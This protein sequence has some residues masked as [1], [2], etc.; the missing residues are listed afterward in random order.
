M[1]E[2]IEILETETESS[3]Q[4][5]NRFVDEIFDWIEVFVHAFVLVILLLTF[6]FRI[7]NVDGSSMYPTLKDKEA[8]VI[9]NLFYEPGKGDIIVIAQPNFTHQPIVKRVIATGGDTIDINYETST[10]YVN[11]AAIEEP[12]LIEAM[13]V[14]GDTPLPL[15]LR[16]GE[17]FVMGDNRNGSTDSRS[18]LIGV[19]DERYV[20]GRTVLR[21][22]PINRMGLVH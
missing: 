1:D 11:G 6:I 8:I 18:N 19:I 14:R 7:V 13:E 12:Y 10:V 22:L 5:T 9:S 2:Q 16:E 17:L 4:G 20:I 3:L 15:T 21:L